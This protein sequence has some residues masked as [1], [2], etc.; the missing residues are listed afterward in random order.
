[1]GKGGKSSGVKSLPF[2]KT[3]TGTTTVTPTDPM[4]DIKA[5]REFDPQFD[6]LDASTRSEYLQAR[7]DNERRMNSQYAA[8]IPLSH[9]LKQQSDF[10]SK[11]MANRGFA[12][13]QG[14][15]AKNR[16]KL[17]QKLTLAGL[18]RGTNAQENQHSYGY[19]SGIAGSNGALAAGLG[20][21]GNIAAAAIM[22]GLLSDEKIKDN[23]RPAAPVLDRLDKYRTVDFE[24]KDT[25]EPETGVV[26]QEM[27]QSFPE[28][29]GQDEASGLKTV[30]YD[31][32]GA[33][34]LQG[35]KELNKKLQRVLD[36][37]NTETRS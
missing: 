10:A 21:G 2:D 14:E 30:R 33:L 11:L 9:R 36:R 34:A 3:T 18:T 20:A 29:V 22:M 31:K 13:S 7:D 6:V 37:K 4:G 23:I 27:E 8:G 35:V 26:A 24:R 17:Q 19:E 28:V 15:E 16:L 25:G 12:L 32:L 5:A 1:M